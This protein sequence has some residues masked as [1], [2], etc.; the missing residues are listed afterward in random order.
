MTCTSDSHSCSIDQKQE[1]YSVRSQLQSVTHTFLQPRKHRGKLVS[2]LSSSVC[3]G[4]PLTELDSHLLQT[5]PYN[6]T[7]IG[8][9]SD[10]ILLVKVIGGLREMLNVLINFR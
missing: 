8:M 6:R 5:T 9:V 10:M 4:Q 7:P 2:S 1:T 3:F